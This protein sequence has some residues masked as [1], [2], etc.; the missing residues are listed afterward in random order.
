MENKQENGSATGG[1]TGGLAGEMTGKLILI[2]GPSGSG[3]GTVLE[4]L[5]AKHPDFVFPLSC[6]TRAPRPSEK[7]GEVYHFVSQEQFTERVNN[8]DF[9]EWAVVH[10]ENRYGT[11]KDEILTPLREGKVVIR[12]VDVQGLRSI[13]A[14]I[15]HKNLKSLF[16]TVD[17]WATLQ[18][19]ILKRS[20]LPEEELSRR[21]ASFAHEME[22]AKEC[23]T[24]IVS[25]EGEIEKLIA[26]VEE[27][28]EHM[29]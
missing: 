8:G 15:P 25:E 5:R 27:A 14:I 2:L 3:K 22:W 9:L 16:L 17:G 24:V 1:T 28:I 26:D 13:S 7:D 23:D 4:A 18:R 6:T 29:V 10:A 20:A 12:E 11:L 19:R 21:H